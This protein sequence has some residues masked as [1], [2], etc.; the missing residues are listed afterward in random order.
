MK[1][2]APEA[3]EASFSIKYKSKNQNYFFLG[4]ITTASP[5]IT[6]FPSWFSA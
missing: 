1:K 5:S 6:N 3:A 4:A 2:E